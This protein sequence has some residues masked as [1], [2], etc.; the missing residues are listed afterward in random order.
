MTNNATTKPFVSEVS[1]TA[2]RPSAGNQS[3]L[4][5]CR[6][7]ELVRPRYLFDSVTFV[8][9]FPSHKAWNANARTNK[10]GRNITLLST[11]HNLLRV[12]RIVYP[13][14]TKHQ[15]CILPTFVG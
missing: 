6:M 2:N 12:L 8:L 7:L 3:E 11:K 1:H 9:L 14:N 10:I 4:L 15:A 5:M 13:R